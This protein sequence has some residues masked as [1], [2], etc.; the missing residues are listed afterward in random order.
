MLA[1]VWI[2]VVVSVFTPPSPTSTCPHRAQ[3]SSHKPEVKIGQ[4]GTF[5][6]NLDFLQRREEHPDIIQSCPGESV[7]CQLV[8]V[9]HKSG[10]V[11]KLVSQYH[12]ACAAGRL[13]EA[14][15]FAVQALALD[16][17]CFS[18]D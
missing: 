5:E 4:L 2:V 18:K 7:P 15:R 13:A 12:R 14:T 1:R 11:E 8:P 6:E 17:A 10:K 3:E 16:P 9:L